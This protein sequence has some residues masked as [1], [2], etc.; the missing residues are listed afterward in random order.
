MNPK[1][2]LHACCAPCASHPAAE[3]KRDFSVT[4]VFYGSNI[5]PEIEY[6]KRLDSASHL[7]E[8]LKLELVELEYDP[9][10]WFNAVKGLEKEPEGS[11]RCSICYR[12]RLKR[13]AEFA[14]Q[15]GYQCFATTLTTSPHKPAR[16]I[17]PIGK[18]IA[19]KYG[20]D[21]LDKDFKRLDG[22]KKSCE[23][24]KE[25]G[26]YRQGYCGCVYSRR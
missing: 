8:R 9:D 21:F 20:L 13:I 12:I 7:S 19:Q 26:L 25:Y 24:S 5:H 3:L 10:A 15:N 22:F 1:L 16:I 4:L 14:K 18:E 11:R 2:L 6:R 23:L 17:N